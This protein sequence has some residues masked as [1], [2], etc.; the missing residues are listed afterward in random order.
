M[1]KRHHGKAVKAWAWNPSEWVW[2]DW[3]FT[4]W[5]GILP[6]CCEYKNG[7][8]THMPYMDGIYGWSCEFKRMLH[9]I[10]L[11]G[12]FWEDM[13][14]DTGAHGAHY[15]KVKTMCL[16]ISPSK[17]G[18]VPRL[19]EAK[20]AQRHGKT[21]EWPDLC[22]ADMCSKAIQGLVFWRRLLVGHLCWTPIV[23]EGAG[24]S[25]LVSVLVTCITCITRHNT[26]KKIWYLHLS[27]VE[28][29]SESFLTIPIIPAPVV[30][31]GQLVSGRNCQAYPR[32]SKDL[33][34]LLHST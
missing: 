5:Q 24:F 32:A 22:L 23:N 16:T 33:T 10:S 31:I 11:S 2:V 27:W 20:L 14:E 7:D 4:S 8:M 15:A 28:E 19:H 1:R 30:N 29:W 9:E 34:G 21:F 12:A 3:V 17:C 13:A 25:S 6:R 26:T 18:E